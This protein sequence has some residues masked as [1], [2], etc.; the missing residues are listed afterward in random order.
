M[1]AT[2]TT[3]QH[4]TYHPRVE[5]DVLVR[6]RGRYAADAPL[7]NQA[8]AYFVRSPHAFARI[9]SI[10]I[11]GAAAAPGVIGVLT[12]TDMAGTGNI[13]RH[14]PVPRRGGKGLVIPHRPALATERVV[15]IGEPVAMVVAESAA[16]AQD[17]GEFVSVEYEELTPVI[18]AREAL[19]DGAPQVWPQAPGNIAVDW[20][21]PNPDPD[22]NA[23]K[24]EEIFAAAKFTARVALMNQRM[25]G[26]PM[27]PRGATASY[28][29]AS[30]SYTT[31]TCSQGAGAMREAIMAIMNLPKERIRVTTEDVGGAFGIKT[32]PYPENIALLVAAKKFSRPIHWMS[33][34]A[35]VFLTDNQARDIHTDVELALNDKGKFMAPRLRNV[36]NLGAYVGP[37]G[38]NIPTTNFA[39]CL[40]SMYDIKHIDV[41][42]KCVFT[43]TIG[44]RPIAAPGGRRRATRSNAWSMKQRASP[45]SIRSNC[46][47]AI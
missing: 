34:R 31:R 36:G 46:G 27:E 37:V 24:V 16:A 44:P 20:P 23:K 11:A 19:R 17:A 38:A 32:G 45:A 28:D 25:V 21:G 33:T 4:A 40:P 41:A 10:D 29:A 47:G 26:N 15:H 7:P 12:G 14:P 30:D 1:D 2:T 8:F 43:N 13:G 5:D 42:T 6:G 3:Q 35:E 18:D 39:R 22:A 9:V